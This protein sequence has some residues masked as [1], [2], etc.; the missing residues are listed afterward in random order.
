MTL[1]TDTGIEL[2]PKQP[3]RNL[4]GITG[5]QQADS[6]PVSHMGRVKRQV[7]TLMWKIVQYFAGF[8]LDCW[9]IIQRWEEATER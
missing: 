7:R 6:R 1:K 4:G 5:L 8:D 9:L 2:D 3:T